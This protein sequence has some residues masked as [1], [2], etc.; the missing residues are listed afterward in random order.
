MNHYPFYYGSTLAL[1]A[2]VLTII[3][4]RRRKV[5]AIC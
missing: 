4:Y 5:A 3:Y 1:I 2:S